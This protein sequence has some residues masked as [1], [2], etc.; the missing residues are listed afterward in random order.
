MP[1]LP[2]NTLFAVLLGIAPGLAAGSD[3]Q[4]VHQEQTAAPAPAKDAHDAHDAHVAHTAVDES[5][6]ARRWTPDA[7]LSRGMQRVRAATATLEHGSHGHLDDGQVR[8]IAAE[9]KSAVDMM[10]AEC[11]LEPEPDAALHPLLARVL[12]ASN[13]LSESGFDADALAEL[14]A[15]VARYPLLFDDPA[16]S[17]SQSD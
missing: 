2:R 13:T 6:P 14:Q 3:T 16:W 7:P 4:P 17:A 8:N 1:R 10:F 11:K 15:V 9:L 12:V 5:L